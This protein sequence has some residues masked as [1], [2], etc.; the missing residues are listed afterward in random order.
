MGIPITLNNISN[1][2]QITT[3]ATAINNNNSTII[4][5][6]NEVLSTNPQTSNSMN[7]NLDMNSNQILNLPAPVAA[8]SPARLVD[9]VS[10]P[11]LTLT[12]PPVG[13]SGATVPLL[14]GNNT[15]SGYNTLT[16]LSSPTTPASGYGVVYASATNHVLSYKNP[17]GTISRT[18]VPQSALTNQYMTAISSDG[19]ISMAQPSVSN[20]SD[21]VT[22]TGKVV[23]ATSPTIATPTLS[24][25]TFTTAVTATNLITNASLAQMA[26]NTIKGNNTGSTANA[27]DL[28]VPQ[29][30][31]LLNVNR[32]AI[33]TTNVNFNSANTDNAITVPTLPTGFTYYRVVDVII[34][35]A[36]HTMTTATAG[37]F[38]TTG[39]GGTAIVT[40]A[41]MT[42]TSSTA[43]TALNM[44]AMTIAAT[45]TCYNLSTL[46]FRI[47]TAEGATCT[48]T[49]T[50]VI[51]PVS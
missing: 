6:L 33:V 51:Q 24:S 44:Q 38:P 7:T 41:S 9:V 10:N 18:V 43:N 13:T 50:I 23:L 49:V 8:N 1:A 32:I 5:A 15:W 14:N 27:A 11:T 39:G 48:G 30:Q 35:A 16:E 45:T 26:T 29:T 12:I 22:G 34:T 17:S 36:T 3:A 21:G 47:G 28:T 19:V 42:N 4:T 2:Q 40:S 46:Y 20:L 37:L 25:P 31:A